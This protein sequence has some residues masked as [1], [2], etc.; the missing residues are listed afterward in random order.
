MAKNKTHA[1]FYSFNVLPENEDKFVEYMNTHGTPIMGKYCKNWNLFKSTIRLNGT[2][3]PQYIGYFDVP[4]LDS[5]LSSKP[6][7]EMK[8]IMKR[9]NK[10]CSNNSEWISE[11]MF[12][13]QCKSKK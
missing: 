5:F 7:E 1:F 6:P 9:S 10:L 8:D 4:D 3:I 13:N 11:L 2:D 12:T